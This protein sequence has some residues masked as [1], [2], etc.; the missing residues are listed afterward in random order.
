M[1]Y[2]PGDPEGQASHKAQD[3]PAQAYADHTL[4]GVEGAGRPLADGKEQQAQPGDHG[5]GA[6]KA[7]DS[8]RFA[9]VQTD[10]QRRQEEQALQKEDLGEKPPHHFIVHSAPRSGKD[11][12]QLPRKS[13]SKHFHIC[14]L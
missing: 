4:C 12:A 9:K 10:Q 7:R 5:Y 3:D 2:L 13:C 1:R 14:L 6:Y 8:C 11:V